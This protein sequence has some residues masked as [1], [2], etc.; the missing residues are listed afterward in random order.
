M[1]LLSNAT[2]FTSSGYILLLIEI[3]EGKLV[4]TVRDT[5]CGI[6]PSFI[7]Q[8]FDPFTQA[9]TLGAHRGTGL[10]LSIIKQLLNKMN[11]D[12]VVD[13]KYE[14]TVGAQFSGSQFVATIPVPLPY[15]VPV[16]DFSISK[17]AMFHEGNDR[18]LEGVR[19]AWKQYGTEVVLVSDKCELI[20]ITHVWIDISLLQKRP[21]LYSW[22][23]HQRQILVLVTYEAQLALDYVFGLEATPQNF[24]TVRKPLIWHSIIHAIALIQTG[25]RSS[26]GKSVRFAPDVDLMDEPVEDVPFTVLLVEDNKIN[27]RL[28]QKM[29]ATLKY[30]VLVANDGQEAIDQ[31]LQHDSVIDAILMDQS[32]PKKDGL[33][34]TK[35]IRELERDG[36]LSKRHAII[37]VTAVVSSESQGLS[38]AAGTDDFLAKPVS[39][40]KLGACLEK[41]LKRS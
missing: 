18:Y 29:L 17:V 28:M 13:S 11:G 1:N 35:E 26:P 30:S 6:P 37:A 12:I 38:E 19:E 33:T 24:I 40:V 34:A 7:P 36:T 10:G 2:K 31:T 41:W 9:E 15:E 32:M 16:T 8:L 4:A 21:D 27:L 23:G 14:A 39:L 5:G 25:I 3:K 22:L 20:N